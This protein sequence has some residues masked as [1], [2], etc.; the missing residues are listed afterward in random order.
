MPADPE[1]AMRYCHDTLVPDMD[2]VR[3]SAD[4]LETITAAE[5]WPFPVYSDLLFSV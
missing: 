5:Y 1:K 3:A 2:K 4:S